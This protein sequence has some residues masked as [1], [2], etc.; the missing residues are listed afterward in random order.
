M[1][2][3]FYRSCA[4][5]QWSY[6]GLL[7]EQL[8]KHF[9]PVQLM[10][11][12]SQRFH[13]R[14]HQSANENVDEFAQELNKLFHK[15]YSNLIRGGAEAEAM[16]QSVLAN[17]FILG[18]RPILKSKVVGTEGNLEQLLV[19]ARFE[20]PKH[21]ELSVGN[22]KKTPPVTGSPPNPNTSSTSRGFSRQ[23]QGNRADEPKG[24]YNCGM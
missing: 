22:L 9:A 2:F 4:S 20:K 18:L 10:A 16:G 11:I 5:E 12:Q 17:Q 13:D 8:H 7:V 19:K 23:Q 21:R 3:S 15:A 6:Y 14:R 1:A 24:C